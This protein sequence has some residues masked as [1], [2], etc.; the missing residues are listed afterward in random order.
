MKK[1]VMT[2]LVL[3]VILVPTVANAFD[4][5]LDVVYI[6]Q[7]KFYS[8]VH[9]GYRHHQLKPVIVENE[10][11]AY[12]R[13]E[14]LGGAVIEVYKAPNTWREVSHNFS[15]GGATFVGVLIFDS[16]FLYLEK[17]EY[18]MKIKS[19]DDVSDIRLI[20]GPRMKP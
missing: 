7:N 4:W 15:Q 9:I 11:G 5:N 3:A 12:F 10:F 8:G 2:L 18:I 13:A 16:D 6:Y 19:G 20:F 17:G 14:Q 1:I